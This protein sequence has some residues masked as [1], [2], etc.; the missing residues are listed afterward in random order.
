M[1]LPAKTPALRDP[2]GRHS[3]RPLRNKRF[4]EKVVLVFNTSNVLKS[5]N[6]KVK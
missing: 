4:R 3:V 2:C 1:V 6:F 5:G